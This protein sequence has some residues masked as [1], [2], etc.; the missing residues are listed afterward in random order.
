MQSA[1][2]C[3]NVKKNNSK[4]KKDERHG[5]PFFFFFVHSMASIMKGDLQG[6]HVIQEDCVRSLLQNTR[7]QKT[8]KHNYTNENPEK[9]SLNVFQ[10]LLSCILNQSYNTTDILLNNNFDL[11]GKKCNW[12]GC[13]Y[14]TIV[15]VHKRKKRPISF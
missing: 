9:K 2:G 14:S 15:S 13:R 6:I 11:G 4:V 10:V 12:L 7:R 5:L 3:N 8:P 1:L